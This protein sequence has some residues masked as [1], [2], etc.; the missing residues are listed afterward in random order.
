M[1]EIVQKVRSKTG[2][3]LFKLAAWVSPD[4]KKKA[5]RKKVK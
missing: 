2:S 1:E 3:L 4:K 5:T